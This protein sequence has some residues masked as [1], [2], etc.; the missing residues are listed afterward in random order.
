MLHMSEGGEPNSTYDRGRGTFSLPQTY[1]ALGSPPS[2][3]CNIMFT[4][5]RHM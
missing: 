2:V 1:V 4:S 3:I 5:L